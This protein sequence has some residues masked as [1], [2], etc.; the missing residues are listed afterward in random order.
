MAETGKRQ[1]APLLAI[2]NL[3]IRFASTTEAGS[4]QSL[5]VDSFALQ[6]RQG[7]MVGLV[8][9]SGSGKSVS[10][11]SIPQLLPPQARVSP[12][13]S[14]RLK[15]TEMIGLD[16]Q[17][18]RQMRARHIGVVF[19]EPMTALHPAH[20]IGMQLMEA[21]HY[22]AEAAHGKRLGRGER[23]DMVLNLLDIVGLDKPRER[24][25]VYPHQLSGGQRQRV[26][27]AMALAGDP[28]LLIADEPTTALDVTVQMQILDQLAQLQS[29]LGMA[30]LLISHDLGVVSRLTSRLCVMQQGRIVE[31]G[32][33]AKVVRN[34]QNE[35]TL[36]LLQAVPTGKAST[37]GSD[38]RRARKAS[39]DG[40]SLLQAD[41]VSVRFTRRPLFLV[42][43]S[44]ELQAVDK[45]SLSLEAGE[46]LGIVGESGCGK[47]TLAKSLVGLVESEGA[48][49]WRGQR[50]GK[51]RP[52][53]Y[54]RAVQFMF[55]DPFG[56]LSPRLTIAE[57]IGEGLRVHQPECD[58][59][60]RQRLASDM[61][62]EV[63]LQEQ[64]LHRFPHELSGGQR[65]R[66]ALAR[67]LVLHPEVLILDEPTSALDMS[68]QAQIVEL[69]EKLQHRHGIAYIFISHDLKLVQA[70]S[71]HV[72]VMYRG[73]VVEAGD[74]VA[75]F[76][77]PKQAYTQQLVEAARHYEL[78]PLQ[79]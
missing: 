20:R 11:M 28:D 57:I 14:I 32:E 58:R 56:A 19:Q 25:E 41:E 49:K 68:V 72:I 63:G 8:G 65:Q 62:A 66:V 37:A 77:H 50:L 76:D 78:P 34:P 29:D 61:M 45:V 47:S 16:K 70:L 51:E 3:S 52:D 79:A 4:S 67:A 71:D 59:H 48:I 35:Y 39:G 42:G 21:V 10:A 17:Q 36:G 6:I 43:K 54:K 22:R 26:L 24:L 9:E 69:L 1:Q 15:D 74:S 73:Q 2:E 75:I 30:V 7:E 40:D 38:K 13:S 60:E 55:Q 44:W 18:L 5:A 33:S 31:A 23:L 64:M 12:Q 27:I 46:T 53:T